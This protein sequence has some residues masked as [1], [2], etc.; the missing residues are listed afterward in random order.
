[1]ENDGHTFP[2]G[3]DECLRCK[4]KRTIYEATREPCPQLE[5]PIP[6]EGE[7]PPPNAGKKPRTRG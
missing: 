7:R 1:M 3:D 4:M 6:V 5:K 2:T